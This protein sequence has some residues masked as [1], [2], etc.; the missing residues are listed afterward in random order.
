[1]IYIVMHS[2][3]LF[4]FVIHFVWTDE[5]MEEL[6]KKGHGSLLLYELSQHVALLGN[7]GNMYNER[8]FH[9][10]EYRDRDAWESGFEWIMW[11]FKRPK[12]FYK[13]F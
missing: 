3:Q 1:M 2:E 13:I 11:L 8:Y 6:A 12:Y 7:L 4:Y 10:G 9:K 5:T